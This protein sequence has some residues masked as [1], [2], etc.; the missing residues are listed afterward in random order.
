[1]SYGKLNEF[2]EILKPKTVTDSEGFGN[3]DDTIIISIRA[4][5]EERHGSKYWSNMASFSNATALFK[6]R[7]IPGITID[8]TMVIT[9]P[10]GR[11]KIISV[12]NVGSRDMYIE[13][14]AE[15]EVELSEA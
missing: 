6:F 7:K 11:Y 13:V 12:Q 10:E 8:T 5:R 9:C 14:L 1:M 15:K 2:I 3:T 4:Y